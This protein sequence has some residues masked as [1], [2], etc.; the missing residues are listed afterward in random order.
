MILNDC[1]YAYYIHCFAHCLQL[2]LVGVSKAIVPL[3][4]FFTK[5]ILVINNIHAS[6]KRIKQLKI[7]RAFDIAYLIDIEELETRKGLN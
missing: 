4:R 7:A 6:C 1:L 2:A 3:N 5:L